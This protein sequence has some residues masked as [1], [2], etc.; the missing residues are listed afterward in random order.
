MLH[1]GRVAVL[2]TPSTTN[3][4]TQHHSRS[5]LHSIHSLTRERKGEGGTLHLP[6]ADVRQAGRERT[7]TARLFKD[8]IKKVGVVVPDV[9]LESKLRPANPPRSLC[10]L[11]VL[12]RMDK[13]KSF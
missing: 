3:G 1:P 7:R 4:D 6:P 11:D 12:F 9:R 8:G 2:V 10:P 5:E 13:G